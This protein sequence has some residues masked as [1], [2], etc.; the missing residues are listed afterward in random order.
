[1]Q[2][3]KESILINST[4]QK[5]FYFSSLGKNYFT[6]SSRN[7]LLKNIINGINSV[8]E[9]KEFDAL[10]ELK[11]YLNTKK[12]SQHLNLE[13]KTDP[14]FQQG[15]I[16]RRNKELIDVLKELNLYKWAI[17]SK[18]ISNKKYLLDKNKILNTNEFIHYSLSVSLKINR[19]S[20]SIEVGT[21][22]SDLSKLNRDGLKS[23]ITDIVS[24]NRNAQNI[25]FKE[26]VPVVLDAGD[27]AI[28]FHEIIGHSL[29][30]DYIF[31]KLSQFSIQDIGKKI[32]S[33]TLTVL[34]NDDKDKFFSGV[35]TDD[36]GS[37]ISLSP[38]ISK[39]VLNKILTDRYYSNILKLENSGNGRLED[40]IKTVQ[41]RMYS[42]FIKNG[43]FTHNDI[44]ESVEYGV[45]AKE[46]GEGNVLFTNKSFSLYVKEAY[47]IQNGKITLPLGSILLRGRIKDVLN[48]VK[49]I[50]DNF[51]YDN[52]VSY[53]YK[54]GQTINV[55][56]GQPTVKI[57]GVKVSRY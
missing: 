53:C 41:P 32:F 28:L 18:F 6:L 37:P 43:N 51:R 25:E 52:G 20:S 50:G 57:E 38:L 35:I 26:T 19:Q 24:N 45:Y 21:G 8:S 12:I 14:L 15:K 39:G 44:I 2:N 29:E 30:A 42:I 1:L 47:L 36:E 13:H 33:K 40:F 23:R 16:L 46:F 56:V 4:Q 22:K 55:R 54:N 17:N 49:M 48:S 27:G 11:T 9:S 10:D 5:I 3:I 7:G 31:N 34:T